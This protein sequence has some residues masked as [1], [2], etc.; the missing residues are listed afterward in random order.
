MKSKEK[1]QGR[2]FLEGGLRRGR[3]WESVSLPFSISDNTWGH[4][5]VIPVSSTATLSFGKKKQKGI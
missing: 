5:L 2:E 1:K 4:H 3:G